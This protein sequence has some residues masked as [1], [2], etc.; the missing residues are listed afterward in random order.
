MKFAGNLAGRIQAS[1]RGG[2]LASGH[3]SGF[4][5]YGAITSN[6]QFA[7]IKSPGDLKN[8]YYTEG[9][10]FEMTAWLCLI[11]AVVV[12]MLIMRENIL[13]GKNRRESGRKLDEMGL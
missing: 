1:F 6:G 7:L 9:I 2:I 11:H 12:P 4:T 5:F 8:R 10:P 13:I 3:G